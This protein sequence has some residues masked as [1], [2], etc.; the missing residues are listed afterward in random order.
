MAIL[1]L[2]DPL[3]FP[4]AILR[5][6]LTRHMRN[7]TWQ[8]GE[9]DLGR[10]DDTANLMRPQVIIGRP[11]DGGAPLMVTVEGVPGPCTAAGAPAHRSHITISRPTVDDDDIAY[12]A[13]VI[14]ATSIALQ[15]NATNTQLLPG[16]KWIA[17]SDLSWA[18]TFLDHDQDL[19]QLLTLG[20]GGGDTPAPAPAQPAES[21]TDREAPPLA[22]FSVLLDGD[23]FIDWNKIN[24]AMPVI[25]PEGGWHAIAVPGGLGIVTG[26]AKIMVLWSPVPIERHIID[27]GFSRS[28][29]FDGDRER[30]YRNRQ[31]ITFR[32]DRSDDFET[33]IATAKILT[34]IL[35][36]VVQLPQVSAVCNHEV[37]TIFTPQQAL[38]QAGILAS[39]ELP[40]QL[41]TWT[42]PNSMQDGDVSLTTGGMEP[43]VGFEVEVWNA[44]HPVDFVSDKMSGVLRYLLISGPVIQHGDTIGTEPGDRSIRCFFGD[45]R[46]DRNRPVKAMFLEFDVAGAA[47]PRRDA[48][49]PRPDPVPPPPAAAPAAPP[50]GNYV[51][52]PT[53]GRKGL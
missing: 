38:R 49:P 44:P 23:V 6:M 1:L 31:Y 13:T 4:V 28:F 51:R 24:E 21:A 20:T 42:A 30:V 5:D 41:W 10:P 46:A 15:S 33:R 53:F 16:G 2:Q 18:V 48:P 3:G 26:R 36:I 45:T 29:W 9:N 43:L 25:D 40:I 11:R 47:E 17:S 37:A 8:V 12:R 22:S 39:N 14:V 27:S 50:A 7:W 19:R 35:G 34:L 52:R 32:A